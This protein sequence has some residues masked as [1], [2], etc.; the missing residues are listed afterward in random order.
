MRFSIVIPAYNGEKFVKLAVESCIKQ[1]RTADEI[2][3]VDDAST[4]KTAEV[5][6]PYL[7][8]NNVKYFYNHKSTGF[9]DAWNRCIK[10]ATGDFVTILHQ[11]DLLHPEYLKNVEKAAKKF[12]KARHFYSACN[13]VDEHGKITQPP[14]D[15]HSIEPTLYSGKK[16]AQNYLDGVL[17]NKHIHRCP[18]VTTSRDLLARK[19][20][21]RKEA[22]HIADD[23]FFY[24]VGM[25]TDVVGI[26]QPLASFRIH[27]N[28]TTG[29][30]ANLSS[31]LIKD[32]FFQIKY[33]QDSPTLFNP[34]DIQM[35]H[36]ITSKLMT[37]MLVQSII[38][39]DDELYLASIDNKEQFEKLLQVPYGKYLPLWGQVLW[40]LSPQRV[41]HRR[42]N[43]LSK[44]IVK[45]I[46]VK[47][48]FLIKSD[49]EK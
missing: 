34:K 40:C 8:K 31:V 17:K 6:K 44:I 46:A 35:F 20:T 29:Q 42:V 13:Y 25:F 3:V 32:Y 41:N 28:S 18:G 48:Y 45:L 19:C 9:V 39:K 38:F 24:R 23:D 49:Y 21:Y 5:I 37:Q 16:Y 30:Q 43:Y 14:Q 1:S 22:G 26:S 12:P 36:R 10:K 11:D 2:I 47:H 33:H 4:D 27:A 7:K 15:F